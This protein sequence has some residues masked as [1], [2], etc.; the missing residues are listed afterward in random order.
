MV[1]SADQITELFRRQKHLMSSGPGRYADLVIEQTGFLQMG[2][3]LLFHPYGTASAADVTGK[4]QK[5]LHGNQFH[6]FVTGG[7]RCFF[8]V[9]L[10]TDGNTKNMDPGLGATGYQCFENLFLWKPQCIRRVGSSEIRFVI[11]VKEFP[12]GNSCLLNQ[13]YSVGFY[14]HIDHQ[15]YYTISFSSFAA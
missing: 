3:I 11:F 4:S 1:I 8:E 5:L 2:R 10:T 6:A 13:P 15:A 12:A 7:F 14:C 9:K